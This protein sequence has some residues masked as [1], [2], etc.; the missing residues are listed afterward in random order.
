MEVL[1]FTV[2]AVLRD[3][4]GRIS[5]FTAFIA[6]CNRTGN[7]MHSK[8]LSLT[9][10]VIDTGMIRYVSY[11]MF[12]EFKQRRSRHDISWTHCLR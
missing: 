10:P 3:T 12:N 11:D 6:E 5:M 2:N 7:V 1:P 9:S 4:Y 8:F